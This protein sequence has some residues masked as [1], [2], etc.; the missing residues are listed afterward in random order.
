MTCNKFQM[1]EDKTDVLF[2]TA[3]RV[4]NLQH[5]PELMNI[6][7]TCVKFSPSFKNLDVKLNSTLLLHSM[8]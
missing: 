3:E 5:L 6:N 7:V 8:S 1:N 2:V 4:V